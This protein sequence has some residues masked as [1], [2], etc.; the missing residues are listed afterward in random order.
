LRISKA[1][2]LK[3]EPIELR[4]ISN[5]PNA[6]AVLS[7]AKGFEI[8]LSQTVRLRNG[9]A[10]V[11]LP[12]RPEFN[13]VLS[14]SA[15]MSGAGNPN[16]ANSRSVIYPRD[17][18]LKVDVALDRTQYRPGDE[19]TARFRALTG[20]GLPVES[21]LGISVVDRAVEER[22]RT[23]GEFGSIRHHDFVRSYLQDS[24]NVA[25]I[26]VRDLRKLDVTQPISAELQLAAEILLLNGG[27]QPRAETSGDSNY[28]QRYIFNDLMQQTLR[29][30]RASLDSHYDKTREYPRDR[31]SLDRILNIAEIKFEDL[32]DPWGNNFRV[33]F[34]TSRERDYLNLLC[35]GADKKFGTADDFPIPIN[36]WF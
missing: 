4:L 13:D 21:A 36:G 10:Y 32:R 9:K 17:N 29:P 3:G 24:Q 26:T 7:I 2:Y 5:R 25:G 8:L 19:A 35:A 12:Y 16:L 20:E 27:Y 11:V 18:E 30:L 34:T 28:D 15:L 14:I 22:A 23:N 31:E 1:I 33:E 6:V